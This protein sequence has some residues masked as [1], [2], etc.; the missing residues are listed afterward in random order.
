[1][2]IYFIGTKGLPAASVV[3]GG[4]VERHV[5]E[6]AT[7]LASRG[8]SVYVYVRAHSA[9]PKLKSYKGVHLIRIPSI[10]SKNLDTITHTFLATLSVLF[11]R[12]DIIHYHGIGPGTLSW[13]PRL[14]KPRAKTI[15]TFHSRDRMDPKWSWFA[16]AY[17]QYAEWAAL[18]FPNETI[19]VSHL[20]QIFCRDVF[21]RKTTY[22]P[23]GADI[24]KPQG[25]DQLEKFGVTSGQYLLG[26]GR[27]VPNKCYDVLME[28][29]AKVSSDMPIVIA[30][31]AEFATDH[32]RK[33]QQLAAADPRIRLVGYQTGE[34]LAQ[35]YAHC[36]AFVHPSRAEG[37]STSVLEA[38]ANGKTVI[39]TDIK[40]NLELLDHSGVVF[41]ADNVRILRD[42]LAWV[43]KDPTL[44]RVRGER[45]R[46]FV[47]KQYSWNSVVDQLE[48]RY[49]AVKK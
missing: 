7:R 14:F 19:V 37:L 28:A 41:P 13:I 49:H 23:N 10:H 9:D 40:E 33:L 44:V 2:R 46:E 35:L 20:L 31:D 6:I 42:V 11:R 38:M 21:G 8:H 16:R 36:Y 47:R 24:P 39:L 5:E 48:R 3:G 17:L 4:G 18:H 34:A 26:V 27:L 30:G 22:I 43:L 45:A 25:D 32:V 29:Y 12:A 15:V 1:M